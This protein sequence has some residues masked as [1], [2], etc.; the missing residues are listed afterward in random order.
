M[1]LVNTVLILDEAICVSNT[2]KT[3]E[4]YK[5]TIFLPTAKGK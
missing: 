4:K 2:A 3:L 1:D 5:N